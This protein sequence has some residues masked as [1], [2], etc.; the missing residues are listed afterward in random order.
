MKNYR[1]ILLF[2][3]VFSIQ[4]NA[5]GVIDY[6]F[7]KPIHFDCVDQMNGNYSLDG[8]FFSRDILYYAQ[9]CCKRK[10]SLNIKYDSASA[11]TLPCCINTWK[12]RRYD[13]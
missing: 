13:S 10:R 2:L 3:F 9:K 8:S 4:A 5:V 11:K 1:I 7:N 6:C 12:N